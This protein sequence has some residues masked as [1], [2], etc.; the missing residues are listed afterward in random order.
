M[1]C[2]EGRTSDIWDNHTIVYYNRVLQSGSDMIMLSLA[3]TC[4]M[5][6]SP[7]LELDAVHSLIFERYVNVD[8]R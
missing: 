8:D 3:E 4:L 6:V 2:E 7:N 1:K 5:T